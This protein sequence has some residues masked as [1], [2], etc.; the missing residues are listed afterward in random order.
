MYPKE[1]SLQRNGALKY[2]RD[3]LNEYS[4]VQIKL[5]FPAILRYRRKGSRSKWDKLKAF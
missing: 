4:D 3:Y 1:L 5:E 2:R